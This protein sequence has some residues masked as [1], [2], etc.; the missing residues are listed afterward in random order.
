MQRVSRIHSE[1][2]TTVAI[3][4]SVD[5]NGLVGRARSG[6]IVFDIDSLLGLQTDRP[7]WKHLIV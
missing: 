5:V 2:T 1:R 3:T 7:C 6:E 4:V